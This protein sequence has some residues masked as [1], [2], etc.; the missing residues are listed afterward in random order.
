MSSVVDAGFAHLDSLSDDWGLFEHAE[1]TVRRLEHGYC[2][3]DNARLLVVSSRGADSGAPRRLSRLALAF[4]LG[5]QDKAGR[6]RNRMNV[7]GRWTDR[8][9][10]DDCWGRSLW[11]LG[12]APPTT[13]IHW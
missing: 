9:G 7:S 12:V 8:A 4:V 13:R 6:I 3:D 2:T 10:T 1:G 5:A 11:A